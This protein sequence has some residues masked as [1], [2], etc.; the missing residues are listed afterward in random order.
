MTSPADS[1]RRQRWWTANH[2]VPMRSG[3]LALQRGEDVNNV[4]YSPG[5]SPRLPTDSGHERPLCGAFGFIRKSERAAPNARSTPAALL[6]DVSLPLG[7][8][9]NDGPARLLAAR[10][11]RSTYQA[12]T[13]FGPD[14]TGRAKLS[15]DTPRYCSAYHSPKDASARPRW[16]TAFFS[17]GLISAKVAPSC[18]K[19]GS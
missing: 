17:S 18:S 7:V 9:P 4:A 15:R 5:T 16:E 1:N 10:L 3:I 12:L 6:R 19:M 14:T 13:P 11:R 2:N 8:L